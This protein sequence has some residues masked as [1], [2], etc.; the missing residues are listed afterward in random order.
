MTDS[1]KLNS[2]DYNADPA[3]ASNTQPN[4]AGRTSDI[5]E[6]FLNRVQQIDNEIDEDLTKTSSYEPLSEEELL[7]FADFKQ[8]YDNNNDLF[9][10]AASPDDDGEEIATEESFSFT[11]DSDNDDTEAGVVSTADTIITNSSEDENRNLAEVETE[12]NDIAS[13]TNIDNSTAKKGTKSKKSD[14]VRGKPVSSVKLLIAGVVCG[15]LLSA[16]IV[17]ALNSTGIWSSSTDNLEANSSTSDMPAVVENTAQPGADSTV[18][19][20]LSTEPAVAAPTTENAATNNEN[21]DIVLPEPVITPT[22]TKPAAATPESPTA[23]QPS[24]PPK[25]NTDAGI[26]EEDFREEAK[27]TLYR[28]TKDS[29]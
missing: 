27:N 21:N 7:L 16:A 15:L 20:K 12:T 25:N 18:E 6:R 22:V 24:V 10:A 5:Y 8:D 17:V 28:E 3:S 13:D 19:T 11:Y 26:T 23:Q 4:K 14:A 9:L 2:D 1:D 29:L